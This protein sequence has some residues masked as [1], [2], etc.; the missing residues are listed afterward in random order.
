MSAT[1]VGNHVPYC[2]VDANSIEKAKRALH[3][4]PLWRD[5]PCSCISFTKTA[6]RES[7]CMATMKS[8]RINKMAG[9]IVGPNDSAR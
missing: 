7:T 3:Q 2:I 4:Q 9:H 5:T 6:R 1:C 8:L